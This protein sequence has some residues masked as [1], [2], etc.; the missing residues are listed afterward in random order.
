MAEETKKIELECTR[1]IDRILD[2]YTTVE[3]LAKLQVI[4]PRELGT[5][6]RVL[7]SFET[8]IREACGEK[9]V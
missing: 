8:V 9:G 5:I 2:L 4:T 7:G 6:K 3:K 1:G